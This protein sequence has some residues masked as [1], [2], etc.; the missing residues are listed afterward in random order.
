MQGMQAQFVEGVF[1][2]VND[3]SCRNHDYYMGLALD[4]AE[5][6]YASGEV[7]VGAVLVDRQ[8]EVLAR[9]HNCPISE[10]DPSAHAEIRALRQ[11]AS[12]LRN[13]RLPGTII[14]VTLEPCA[15][16]VGALLH[17]RVGRLVFGA[18]DL[19]TGAA[20]GIVDLTRAP[21]L[22]HYMEVVSGV[23][24]GESKELLQRFFRERRRPRSEV[25]EGRGTEVAVTGST[26]NRLVP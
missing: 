13:Y 25:M 2:V 4:E 21:V 14:Y 7:P 1:D 20:G 8:G 9:G 18:S 5:K 22:H 6:A 26:R 12:A 10:C 17:A 3:I 15:M 11:A 19:K 23:R 16:C 24:A